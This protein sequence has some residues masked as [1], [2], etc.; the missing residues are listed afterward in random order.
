M[1]MGD[2]LAI[3]V[4]DNVVVVGHFYGTIQL[5]GT[6]LTWT[7]ADP[8]NPDMILAR[9]DPAGNLA[10]AKRMGAAGEEWPSLSR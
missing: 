6:T 8:Y 10:W 4:N 5:Q 7:A 9:F 1:Q 2:D 3:D